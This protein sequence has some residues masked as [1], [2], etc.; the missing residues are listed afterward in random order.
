MLTV[1]F[2]TGARAQDEQAVRNEARSLAREGIALLNEGKFEAAIAKLEQAEQKFHAPTHL[3]YIARAH[4]GLDQP[5]KAYD[6]YIGIVVEPIPNYAPQAFHE[7]RQNAE[8]EAQ[9]LR[10]R[11]ATVKVNIRGAPPDRATVEIDGKAVH[12]DRLAYPVAV[13]AGS[14][15][16][17][18]SAPSAEPVSRTI[19]T[20]VGKVAEV[21]ITLAPSEDL[22]SEGRGSD[23]AVTPSPGEGADG[24]DSGLGIGAGIA[25]GIGGAALVAGIITGVMTLNR[26]ADI[27]ESCTDNVCPLEQEAEADD[28]KVIGNVST[29]M[30]VVGG[31]GVATGV[32]LLIAAITTDSS[33]QSARRSGPQVHIGPAGVA[34]SGRF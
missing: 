23:G 20:Q 22:P 9:A 13:D 18:A 15:E 33:E 29:A 6:L 4:A 1:L 14:V 7:A 28:A 17:V 19:E 5:R 34:V 31:V 32:A 8:A 24:S 25:F 21:D 26:A 30:F 12:S 16:V 10:A 2:S 11:L 27:K 3:L